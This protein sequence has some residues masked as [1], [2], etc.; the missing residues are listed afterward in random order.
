LP[1]SKHKVSRATLL[2][3]SVASLSGP[4]QFGLATTAP[5][6]IVVGLVDGALSQ[7]GFNHVVSLS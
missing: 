4:L 5:A 6:L 1:S 2:E 3:S 7:A